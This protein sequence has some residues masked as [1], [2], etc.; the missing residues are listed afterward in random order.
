MDEE[1]LQVFIDGTTNYFVQVF[2]TPANVEA[3]YLKDEES[4]ILD[5]TGVIGI[6]GSCRG[7]VYY[8]ASTG[9]LETLLRLLGE[10]D[11]SPHN[12]ADMVGEISN[13]LSGNARQDFGSHFMISVPVIVEGQPSGLDLPSNTRT[14]VIPVMWNDFRSYLIICLEKLSIN[15]RNSEAPVYAE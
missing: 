7:C 4:V 6:S 10:E 8:T 15:A 3:P 2:D 5:Y 11:V 9:M 12:L 13:T 14:F 1:E